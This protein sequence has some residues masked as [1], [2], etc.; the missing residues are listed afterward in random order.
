ML[1]FEEAGVDSDVFRGAGC[2]C[3]GEA[4]SHTTLKRMDSERKQILHEEARE[5]AINECTCVWRWER[6]RERRERRERTEKDKRCSSQLIRPLPDHVMLCSGS[7]AASRAKS[8][9]RRP[10]IRNKHRTW[11]G[12]HIRP[13][14][15]GDSCWDVLATAVRW[16]VYEQAHSKEGLQTDEN[17]LRGWRGWL[18]DV[19]WRESNNT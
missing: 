16:I 4:V 12:W 17:L 19:I 9:T 15:G 18:V 13:A 6:K 11:P 3:G 2:Q 14:C 7:L 5:K 8:D 1:Y 10:G